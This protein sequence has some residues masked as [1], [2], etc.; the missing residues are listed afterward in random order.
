MLQLQ[1]ELRSMSTSSYS[2]FF[3]LVVLFV[4]LGY[5]ISFYLNTYLNSS[6]LFGSVSVRAF[7]R[8]R[9]FFRYPK[10]FSFDDA[11]VRLFFLSFN[12]FSWLFRKK[13]C[14]IDLYQRLCTCTACF[15]AFFC[16][17]GSFRPISLH[18]QNAN[19]NSWLSQPKIA[20]FRLK[21]DFIGKK[22][23]WKSFP[24]K[25]R[26]FPFTWKA[27]PCKWKTFPPSFFPFSIKFGIDRQ[28]QAVPEKLYII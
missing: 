23:L 1:R 22:T 25:W 16:D 17:L 24:Y 12:T 6:T 19:Q 21:H 13:R 4:H 27:F 10:L 9:K 2:P 15:S 28:K 11:K 8:S 14:F 7:W 18:F 20:S 26:T 5:L 3:S